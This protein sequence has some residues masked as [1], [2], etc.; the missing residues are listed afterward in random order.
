MY[1]IRCYWQIV[2]TVELDASGL[3]HG[4]KWLEYTGFWNSDDGT[5]KLSRND[6]CDCS[7]CGDGG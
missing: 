6:C 4:T 3:L 5:D 2:L 1:W 7:Y